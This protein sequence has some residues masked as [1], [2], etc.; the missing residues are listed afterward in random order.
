MKKFY[1]MALCVAVAAFAGCD[2]KEQIPAP[3][4]EFLTYFGFEAKEGVFPEAVK[5]E[6]PEASG[7]ISFTTPVGTD[8][9]AYKG[10][11]PVFETT[12]P[13]AVVT[14]AEGNVITSGEAYDFAE[15]VDI[16]VTMT[17][18]GGETSTM[19]TISIKAKEALSWRL[20]A[21]TTEEAGYTPF[22]AINPK[23]GMPYVASRLN[24]DAGYFP[25]AYKVTDGAF[26]PVVGTS[27]VFRQF[28]TDE[29]SLGF[30]PEGGVY[31]IFRDY[32]NGTTADLAKTSVMKLD[33]TPSFVGEQC[34][35]VYPREV[36]AIF[37]KSANEIWVGYTAGK[38]V[39]S[40][41]S[42]CLE[43]AKW[44][45]AAWSTELEIAGR[46]AADY[47]YY[48]KSVHADG[49]DYMFVYN[50][51]SHSVSLYKL[52]DNGWTTV[53]EALKFN[54][55]DGTEGTEKMLNL[56]S[57][58]CDVA[59]NGDVYFMVGCQFVT[60]TYNVAVVR[61]RPSDQSQTIIGGVTDKD[62]DTDRYF[63]MALD[64]YDVPYIAFRNAAENKLCVQYIDNKTKTWS[65]A[66]AISTCTVED[67][68]TIRFNEEGV[69]YIA[70]YNE[71]NKHIQMYIAE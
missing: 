2:P 59:S 28:R 27:P 13:D 65:T 52:G 58:D 1:L 46:N 71:D 35:M 60:E 10:L 29:V 37:P 41:A 68:P 50:Q 30:D 4:A 5:V 62:I 9:S 38:A 31:T 6:E 23:D 36:P 45:G 44:D 42:R 21:E 66:T 48:V 17:N 8:A 20:L 34:A 57:L 33:G 64:A 54:K 63:S 53:V 40:V 12:S 15:E 22:M 39:G 43:L 32:E 14:D 47:A 67:M 55:A 3:E 24:S 61:Y 19:Y 16:Y 11:V 7:V 69:G 56:R 70:A 26:A 51:N 25:M 18:E 49:V